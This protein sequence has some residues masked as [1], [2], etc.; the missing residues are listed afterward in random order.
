MSL[1]HSQNQRFKSVWTAIFRRRGKSTSN[2]GAFDELDIAKQHLILASA[3]LTDQELPV[4]GS[5]P[6]PETWCLIT[7]GRL[8]WSSTGSVRSLDLKGVAEVRMNIDSMRR[9]GIKRSGTI[10]VY[11]KDG[12]KFVVKVEPGAPYNGILSVLMHIRNRNLGK[13][14]KANR[15]GGAPYLS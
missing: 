7:T 2:S 5:V 10:D 1:G 6:D 3:S 9:H 4:L 13:I 12:N 14:P 11:A 8:I 15:S